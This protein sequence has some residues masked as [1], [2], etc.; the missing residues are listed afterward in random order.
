MDFA[1]VRQ[2]LHAF[3]CRL[4]RADGAAGE[5]GSGIERSSASRD[6]A[7]GLRSMSSLGAGRR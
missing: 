7:A 5:H 1:H 3:A 6:A 4:S 2:R